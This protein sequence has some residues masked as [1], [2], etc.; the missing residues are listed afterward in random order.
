[1]DL[2]KN[3]HKKT[4]SILLLILFSLISLFFISNHVLA[5]PQEQALTTYQI[6]GN[7]K[8][9][10]G[11]PVKGAIIEARSSSNEQA[12]V[13]SEAESL[14]DGTWTLSFNEIPTN[15]TLT[16]HRAHYQQTEVIL[17]N[18]ELATLADG[19]SIFL[20]EI[21]LQRKIDA[22]FWA[23]T[24]IF[25]FVLLVIATEKL[26]STTAS[27]AAMSA[28]FLVSFVGGA[29]SQ[30]LFIFD[31]ETAI[32]YINWE[33]IFL[34]LGMMII[35]A[36]IEKTGLFQ[37]MAFQAYRLSRGK[38][39]LLV[40]ILIAVTSIASALLDNFTTM[41]LM[42]PISL[43]IAIALGINPLALVIPEVLASNISGISTLIGTP[44]NIIIGAYANISFNDFL[45]N[46]TLGVILGLVAMSGFVLFF[47]RKEW[48]KQSGGISPKL[49]EILKKNGQI[50]DKN[51]L[52]KSVVVFVLVLIG[53]VLGERI[54]VVPAVPALVG[55]TFLFVWLQPDVT[56]TLEAVD[57]TTLVF[58]MSLFMVVG[59]VQEVGL[60]SIVADFMRQIIG[61]NL[62]VGLL[63]I[64]FG[65]GTLSTV[66]ANIPLTASLMPVVEFLSGN[67]PG[68]SSKVLYYA[69]SM[70]AAMGGNGFLIG[71]EANLVTAGIMEQAGNRISFKDFLRIGLPVTFITLGFGA[72]WLFIHFIV[73]GA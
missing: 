24:I 54:H 66:I 29:F 65:A 40:L 8:N 26:H 70:G 44:T 68:A 5:N 21:V 47:Y 71:G 15:L 31:F 41:L 48:R 62:V 4:I 3:P 50:R 51:G 7:I 53:F 1:M 52:W 39:W 17:T 61:G 35:V 43:Q 16:I 64:V 73:F 14:E 33:V 49:Y 37:W 38:S 11:Q 19:G 10:Q 72:L 28:I 13:I 56:E 46:Q 27:L 23:S 67:I 20:P 12:P 45:I 55:A 25:V 36:V 57:W 58:F 32:S 2:H 42:T 6:T 60:I 30:N 59:A 9:A 69:L 18:N 63:V 22:G 34:V